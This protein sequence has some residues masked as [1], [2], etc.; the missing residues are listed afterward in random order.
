MAVDV[1]KTESEKSKKAVRR[2][3]WPIV[4]VVVLVVIGVLIFLIPTLVSTSSVRG[5]ILSMVNGRLKGNVQVADFSTSWGGPTELRGLQLSD[6]ANRKVLEVKTVS[7]SRGVW[8]A[9]MS[10]T[11]LGE[12]QIESPRVIL[13]VDK[14]GT[15]SLAG[16]VE[17]R[18]P[19]PPAVEKKAGQ[20]FLP[21]GKL[22][23]VE[24][25]VRIERE[26][27]APYELPS[28][29]LSVESNKLK[30]LQGNLKVTT[31][32]GGGIRGD[33]KVEGLFKENQFAPGKATGT[34]KL[35]TSGGVEIG[36][37]LAITTNSSNAGGKLDVSLNGVMDPSQAKV[38]FTTRATG[39]KA[40]QKGQENLQ[41]IDL[42]LKGEV[43]RGGGKLTAQAV[44]SGPPGQFES[45]LVYLESKQPMD[46]SKENLLAM[47]LDGKMHPL[48]EFTLT[49]K[50]KMDIP[51]LG[52]AVPA[53]LTVQPGVEILAGSIQINDVNI[54][55][56]NQPIA[57]GAIQLTQITAKRGAKEITIQPIVAGFDT[58]IESGQGLTIRQGTLQSEF[59]QAG[60]KGTLRNLEATFQADLAKLK[61]FGEVFEFLS[62][63]VAGAVTGTARLVRASGE[64]L[65]ATLDLTATGLS[66][67]TEKGSVQAQQSKVSGKASFDLSNNR[68]GKATL[69]EIVV[70]IDDSVQVK[71]LG[72]YDMNQDSL[73]GEINVDQLNIGY[74]SKQAESMGVKDP[75]AMDGN[76]VLSIKVD[77]ASSQAGY[78]MDGSGQINQ[79]V[80]GTGEKAFQEAKIGFT[81]RAVIDP[82]KEMVTLDQFELASSPLTVQVK[83]NVQQYKGKGLLDF[84]GQYQASWDR[85]T[86]LLHQY[87]PET[88][89]TVSM[90]GRSESAFTLRGPM[91]NPVMEEVMT[92]GGINWASGRVYGL[93]LGQTALSLL[94][95]K[96]RFDLPKEPIPA[97]DGFIRMGGFVDFHNPTT[98]HMPGSVNLLD[99]IRIDKETGQQ[100]LSRINPIFSYLAELDGRAT[101]QVSDLDLPMSDLIK[102]KGTGRGHLDLTQVHMQPSGLMG[103]LMKLAA[104]ELKK[105]YSPTISGLYFTIENGNF[106]YD[107]FTIAFPEENFDMIFSGSVGLVDGTV[108]LVV[109][110]PLKPAMFGRAGLKGLQPDDA[111]LKG[112]RIAIPLVG[113]RT[114]LK[115]DLSSTAM[116][117]ILTESLKGAGLSPGQQIK[118]LLGPSEPG[119]Q[120]LGQ[121]SNPLENLL[122]S[123]KGASTQPG[124]KEN[125][126]NTL[127]NLFQKG[128]KK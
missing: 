71:A 23:L 24:G 90:A 9:V 124:A 28:I 16:A 127:Q 42:T 72:W 101:L 20:F 41:P 77:K 51:T 100:L 55:G 119:K 11:N 122:P 80:V 54:Q 82:R 30:S 92:K 70:K 108:N 88:K 10:L 36:P 61:N 87:S 96:A 63:D 93:T 89:Q 69:S 6:A 102:T 76:L 58:T 126:V 65:D 38:D 86:E 118:Q 29:S 66:Y 19:S 2:R 14:N 15:T 99:N 83:G 104:P 39:L 53:L 91:A 44:V 26:N 105:S 31:A 33:F 48:P 97:S 3:K 57:K 67:K 112:M 25:A 47:V 49:V 95:Q 125:P 128:K 8:G 35:E 12:V 98:L 114:N 4:L 79:M 85:L 56:G 46:L 59:V 1:K 50:G 43:R 73:H 116:M 13:Y 110:L 75:G 5:R 60:A 84:S 113:T 22:E 17:S 74:A 78:V 40:G 117:K 81:T 7:W 68:L 64:R 120:K 103:E 115:M 52:K 21:I 32:E 27:V 45:Q 37:L 18:I 94:I 123:K 109:S 34:V 121:G 106:R 62:M 107:N 111:Q